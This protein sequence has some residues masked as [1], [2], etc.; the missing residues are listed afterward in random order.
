MDTSIITVTAGLVSGEP[1]FTGTRVPVKSLFDY[2]ASGD[3]LDVY[4]ADYPGVK[5]EQALKAIAMAGE[6]LHST[7]KALLDEKNTVG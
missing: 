4:L 2:L 7:S 3:G 1:V 5:R 6:M